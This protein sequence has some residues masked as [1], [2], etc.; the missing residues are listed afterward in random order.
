MISYTN[1]FIIII[2]IIINLCLYEIQPVLSLNR[3]SL[4]CTI[5]SSCVS[6]YVLVALI[7]TLQIIF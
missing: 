4:M 7:K 1:L 2:I 5:R 6:F 3:L